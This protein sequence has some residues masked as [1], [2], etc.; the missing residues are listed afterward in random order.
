M[1]SELDVFWTITLI[2]ELEV[3]EGT[4]AVFVIEEGVLDVGML[5]LGVFA[6]TVFSPDVGVLTPISVLTAV[7]A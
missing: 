4:I 5:G 6:I 3:S 1:V 7:I 2:L